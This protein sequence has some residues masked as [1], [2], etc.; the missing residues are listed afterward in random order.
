M[1]SSDFFFILQRSFYTHTVCLFVSLACRY[2]DW[3]RQA[4]RRTYSTSTTLLVSGLYVFLSFCLSVFLTFRLS[5][6]FLPASPHVHHTHLSTK[7]TLCRSDSIYLEH[8]NSTR[9]REGDQ[10]EDGR[11][12]SGRERTASCNTPQNCYFCF[13]VLIDS[14]G[15][16]YVCSIYSRFLF[17]FSLLSCS[18][19]A[20]SFWADT[21]LEGSGLAA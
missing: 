13:Y 18:L 7:H 8:G 10:R 17:N 4:S 19:F 5:I 3:S 16:S 1:I 20:L 15:A 21:G 9:E 12:V 11:N 14:Q 6:P 2:L